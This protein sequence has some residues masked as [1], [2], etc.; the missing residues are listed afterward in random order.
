MK[1]ARGISTAAATAT[2]LALTASACSIGSSNGPK[3]KGGP[4]QGPQRVQLIGDGSMA[5]TGPQP[6]QP[7]VERLKP[8]Q[9]PPQ[10]VV[11]SWDG[12][13]ENDWKLFS[14]FR[15][16]A[17]KYHAS[18]TYFLSGIYVV[19]ES[20]RK[21]YAPPRHARGAADI[22]FLDDRDIR[23][24]I[25]QVRE[26]WLEGSEIGTHFNG[27]FCGPDEGVGTWTPKQWKSEIR[28]AEAFV[29]SWRTNTGLRPKDVAPLPFDYRKELVGGRAPC[30]E[31]QKNLMKAE[32]DLGWRY[33]SSSQGGLQVWPEKRNGIWD[34]P[35]QQIPMPGR[36]FETLSMDYNFLANQSKT[37]KGDPDKYEEYED[38]TREG[39]LAGFDRAYESNRA[40]LFIGNHF[41]QWNGGA[42]MRAVEDTIKTV[43]TKSEVR[44]VSFKQLTDWLDAQ[45][46]R[47]LE[48]LRTLD[49]GHEP[50]NG[51]WGAFLSEAALNESAKAAKAAEKA[52]KA[53]KKATTGPTGSPGTDADENGTAGSKDAGKEGTGAKDT[54]KEDSDEEG[55]QEDA[56]T[57]DTRKEDSDEEG[58]Q[59]DAGTEDTG[60]EDTGTEDTGEEDADKEDVGTGEKAEGDEETAKE[61]KKAKKAKKKAEEAEEGR[62]SK[63]SKGEK[64]AHGKAKKGKKHH[65]KHHGS[66]EDS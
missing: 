60:E 26:A 48:R 8:G 17:K 18:M 3:G 21:L 34:Y 50:E 54:R 52:E 14:H 13:G 27:H 28:Q 66:D 57:E 47:I 65:R 61:A 31:G 45:D 32:R 2:V 38:Q 5:N 30:L 16:V 1:S 53:E 10:F 23:R 41:E 7:K 56:G 62:E 42:Y 24:T 15:A 6:N 40:P 4:G 39:F 9:R 51:D 19:P 22:D 63:E 33:D 35:L 55:I 49:V 20:K 11:F 29:G 25:E 43:C 58:I 36:S 46:P 12:A 37:T 44:C 64:K 59:E